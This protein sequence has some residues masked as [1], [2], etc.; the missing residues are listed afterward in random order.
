[1]LIYI[2]FD[3]NFLENDFFMTPLFLHFLPG[4]LMRCMKKQNL[5]P[6]FSRLIF[7]HKFHTEI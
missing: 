7:I 4:Q 5:K 3:K 6:K 2:T 1:M